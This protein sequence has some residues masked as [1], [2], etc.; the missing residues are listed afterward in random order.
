MVFVQVA[1]TIFT[2]ANL[3]L[4]IYRL[5]MHARADGCRKRIPQVCLEL[6]IIGNIC[7]YQKRANGD[8]SSWN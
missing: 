3:V 7:T 1:L 4:A 2:G 5:A 6:I 8:L